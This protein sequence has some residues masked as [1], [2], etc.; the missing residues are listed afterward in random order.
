MAKKNSTKMGCE[1]VE[2]TP[3]LHLDV[4]ALS[5]LEDLKVGDKVT[6]LIQGKVKSIEQREEYDSTKVKGSLGLS[7]YEVKITGPDEWSEMADEDDD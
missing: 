4:K 6:V 5:E 2:W 7:D 1:A 3:T